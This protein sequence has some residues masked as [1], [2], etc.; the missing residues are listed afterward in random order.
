MNKQ[1]IFY[2]TRWNIVLIYTKD[3]NGIT[4][5]R[6]FTHIPLCTEDDDTDSYKC[7]K[8][9]YWMIKW[10]EHMHIGVI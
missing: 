10:S 7:C 4:F 9:F 6:Y 3:I 2:R 1:M 5:Q 8:I